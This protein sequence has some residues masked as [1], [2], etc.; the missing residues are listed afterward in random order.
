MLK[1][2]ISLAAIAGLHAVGHLRFGLLDRIHCKKRYALP[3]EGMGL[4]I[5]AWIAGSPFLT[6]TGLNLNIDTF[7]YFSYKYT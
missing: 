7:F 2:Y 5:I 1:L 4:A 6:P 3:Y